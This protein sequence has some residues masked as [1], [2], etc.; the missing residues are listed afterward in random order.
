MHSGRNPCGSRSAYTASRVSTTSE[1]APR[2][3]P[4]AW[5]S[6]SSGS[7]VGASAIRWRKISVSSVVWKIEP[8]ASSDWRTS[9]ALTRLP[10]WASASGPPRYTTISG[11]VFSSV[12]LPVVE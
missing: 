6:A 1:Y 3:W 7:S 4:A 9:R 12:R 5:I 2:T 11:C 10:L 8:D